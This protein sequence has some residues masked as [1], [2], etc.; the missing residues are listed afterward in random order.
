MLNYEEA[1]PKPLT[2]YDRLVSK[3]TEELAEWFG[4]H[5]CC[6]ADPFFCSKQ[7]GSCKACWLDWLREEG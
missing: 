7:G 6:M 2:N 1:K 3:T 5:A 4:T